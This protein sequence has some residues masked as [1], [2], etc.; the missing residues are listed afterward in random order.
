LPLIGENA[1]DRYSQASLRRLWLETLSRAV[2]EVSSTD[3][4]ARLDAVDWLF[5]DPDFLTVCEWLALEGERMRRRLDERLRIEREECEAMRS[6]LERMV[7][8]Q[9][10]HR[11]LIVARSKAKKRRLDALAD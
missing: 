8:A 11:R 6:E 3:P 9:L 1:C 2:K 7:L 5:H 10:E 4:R